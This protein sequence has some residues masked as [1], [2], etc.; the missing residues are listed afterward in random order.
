MKIGQ[1]DEICPFLLTGLDVWDEAE[2]G[3][4]IGI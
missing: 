3:F 4:G 1:L 2:V